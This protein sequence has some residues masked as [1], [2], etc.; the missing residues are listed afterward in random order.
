MQNEPVE[1]HLYGKKNTQVSVTTASSGVWG[2]KQKQ[3]DGTEFS[4]RLGLSL[5]KSHEPISSAGPPLWDGAHASLC[6]S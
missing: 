3:G 1:L 4:S 5:I 2:K 6:T